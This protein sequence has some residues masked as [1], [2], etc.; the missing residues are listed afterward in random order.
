MPGKRNRWVCPDCRRDFAKAKQ[1][2][3]CAVR[4]IDSH[5]TGKKAPMKALFADLVER[6]KRT[7]PLRVDAVKSGIN[8]ASKH[9]FGGVRVRDGYLRVGFLSRQPIAA[10]RLQ[11]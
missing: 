9:H 6:L 5:F 7:G 1:W 3:S 8:F 11:S 2:H 10:R 4:G